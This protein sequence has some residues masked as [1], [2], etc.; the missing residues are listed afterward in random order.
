MRII[1][2]AVYL[3]LVLSPLS[4]YGGEP[5]TLDEAVQLVKNL[6][7]Q[8][9]S[10]QEIAQFVSKLV[11]K[12]IDNANTAEGFRRRGSGWVDDEGWKTHEKWK[13]LRDKAEQGNFDYEGHAKWAWDLKYGQCGETSAIAYYILKKAGYEN[14][15]ILENS[16]P[17]QWVVIGMDP[18]ADPNDPEDL[19]ERRICSRRMA[20]EKP[21]STGGF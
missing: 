5:A 20:R 13:E 18:K 7:A 10:D 6:K 11:D 8:G 2:L 15:K 4:A 3:L 9:K 17:H 16:K 21:Q 12:R 1:L 14:V 19:G